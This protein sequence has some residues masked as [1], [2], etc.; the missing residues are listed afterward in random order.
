MIDFKLF[1][2]FMM[3]FLIAPITGAIALSF[4]FTYEKR[5]DSLKNK[6]IKA[7]LEKELQLALYNQLNQQIQPHFL[8]NTLNVILS[9]ARLRKT[10]ELIKVLEAFS[11]FLKFNYNTNE[12]LIKLGQEITYT[13]NYIRIQKVRFGSRLSVNVYCQPELLQIYIP[14]FVLQTLV[15]N[16]FKHGLEKEIGDAVLDIQIT[17]NDEHAILTVRNTGSI[18]K[19][20]EFGNGGH[21]LK[22]IS[23]RLSLYFNS[24]ATIDFHNLRDRYTVVEVKWPLVFDHNIR[25]VMR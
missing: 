12:Q 11:S 15:E 4:L 3:F 25:E 17:S 22:N 6:H 8:F 13:Q 10:D 20:Q 21:G 16:A 2:I 24:R 19:I 5:I 9:L 23:T 14:P 18:D 1:S 7:Q